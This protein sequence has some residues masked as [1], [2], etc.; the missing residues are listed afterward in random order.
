MTSGREAE[1]RGPGTGTK[2]GGVNRGTSLH[3]IRSQLPAKF[4]SCSGEVPCKSD[5]G[6]STK[7]S[8]ARGVHGRLERAVRR[9]P[10]SQAARSSCLICCARPFM[11]DRVL[12]PHGQT[13][14]RSRKVGEEGNSRGCGTR[15]KSKQIN[16]LRIAVWRETAG[17]SC[18]RGYCP[19]VNRQLCW[20]SRR[21]KW[22]GFRGK[23]NRRH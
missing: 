12:E 1:Q 17:L 16:P 13:S 8:A 18:G 10:S 3:N 5:G 19:C 9:G 14:Q 23:S 7:E 11:L 20:Q 4:G 21:L 2:W 22:W 6:E 15:R